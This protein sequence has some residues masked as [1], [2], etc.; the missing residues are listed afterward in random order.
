MTRKI[1]PE[2][3]LYVLTQFEQELP[4]IVGIE[5]W[6]HIS[7]EFQEKTSQLMSS[8][9]NAQS[10]ELTIELT[11]MLFPFSS[12]RKRMQLG[13]QRL[14]PERDVPIT[15]AA[16][17]SQI[18]YDK[19]FVNQLKDLGTRKETK[20]V[21]LKDKGISAKSI[22]L[23]NFNFEFG[24]MTEMAA[25]ILASCSD[26]VDKD[27]YLLVTAGVLLIIRS[28]QKA[29][30]VDINEQEAIVFLGTIQACGKNKEAEEA[31]ILS[32]ANLIRAERSLDLLTKKQLKHAL[33]NLSRLKCIEKKKG[34][35]ETW[36]IIERYLVKK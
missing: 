36:R 6:K 35:E 16:I 26:I 14:S 23:K 10:L 31:R 2:D 3:F 18:K 7:N 15:L 21:I 13:L 9:D 29:I 34:E 12:A 17:L 11:D 5:K 8:T 27:D 33:F 22:K 1:N 24:G 28:L 25:G 30:T 4:A 19:S 32:C 20:L